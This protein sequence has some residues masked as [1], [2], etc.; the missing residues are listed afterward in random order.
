MELSEDITTL[1]QTLMQQGSDQGDMMG[2]AKES[3]KTLYED[4]GLTERKT[5]INEMVILS[6]VTFLKIKIAVLGFR[7]RLILFPCV[8]SFL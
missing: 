1:L 7:L 2:F 6:L 8:D 5:K 4:L 3:G